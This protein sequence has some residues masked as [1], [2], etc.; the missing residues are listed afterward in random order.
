MQGFDPQRPSFGS[1]FEEAGLKERLIAM[2]HAPGASFAAVVQRETWQDWLV[3]VILVS[4]VGVVSHFIT[5]PIIADL[6][7]PAVQEQLQRMDEEERKRYVESIELLRAQGWIMVPIGAFTSL[8][9]VAVVLL[10]LVRAVFRSEA[11]YQQMLVVKGYASVVVGVEWIVRTLLILVEETTMVHTGL[12]VFVPEEM[13]RTFAGRVL[14]GVNFFDIWQACLL[15][16]GIAVMGA[17]PIRKAV[18]SVLVLW[19]IWVVGGAAVEALAIASSG[20][21]APMP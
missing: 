11:T 10:A 13:A 18:Y 7:S 6:E 2:F 12:G 9:I 16:A 1:G 20:G 3:P 5:L 15:G 19:G 21:Q 4:V 8:V 14:I 17:I